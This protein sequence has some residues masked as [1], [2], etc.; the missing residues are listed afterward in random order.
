MTGER[1]NFRGRHFRLEDAVYLPRPVQQ[2]HPPIWIGASGERF[3]IPIAAR[4]ADVWH[5]FGSVEALRRK[6]SVLDENA[7]RAGRDPSAIERAS[8]LSISEPWPRSGP[9]AWGWAKPDSRISS[10][11]GRPKAGLGSKSS[12]IAC[13]PRSGPD[14]GR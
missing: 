11:G 1:A 5:C 4:H 8:D 10:W 2:P 12:W 7:R 14:L 13:F 3:T 6:A 9:G